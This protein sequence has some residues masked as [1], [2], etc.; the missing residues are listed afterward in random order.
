M[1][2]EKEQLLSRI[3]ELELHKPTLEESERQ[4]QGQNAE[5]KGQI[6]SLIA[7]LEDAKE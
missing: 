6:T 3:G 4:T 1:R 2:E 5:L 7:A